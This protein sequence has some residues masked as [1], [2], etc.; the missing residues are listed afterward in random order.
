MKNIK[1]IS[2]GVSLLLAAG[3]VAGCGNG[4]TDEPTVEPTTVSDVIVDG[5]ESEDVVE[6]DAEDADTEE[7]EPVS[8][9]AEAYELD[10]VVNIAS[11]SELS[12]ATAG[13]EYVYELVGNITTVDG[14]FPE[15]VFLSWTLDD[16]P[17][18]LTLD[19]NLLVGTPEEAG[20]YTVTVTANAESDDFALTGE[21]SYTQ[22][23]TLVVA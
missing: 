4:D 18:W 16:A 20:E 19:G 3:L 14:N 12:E 21:L 23:F 15:G 5:D 6:E 8:D 2:V 13:A 22:T 7:I 17:E 10:V 11:E 1:K 9:E